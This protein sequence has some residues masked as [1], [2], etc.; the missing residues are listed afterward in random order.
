VIARDAQY[1]ALAANI[2]CFDEAAYLVIADYCEERNQADLGRAWRKMAAD[3]TFP[4]RGWTGKSYKY[5]WYAPSSDD[6]AGRFSY[7]VPRKLIDLV[8]ITSSGRRDRTYSSAGEA[9]RR[10]AWAISKLETG[11]A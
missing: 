4:G 1:K 9:L 5:H 10:L 7:W 2:D 11:N 8:P 6:L 3:K